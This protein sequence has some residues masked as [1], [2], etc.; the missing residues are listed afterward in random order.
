M[1]DLNFLIRVATWATLRGGFD[2]VLDMASCFVDESRSNGRALC[3]SGSAGPYLGIVGEDSQRQ[4][5]RDWIW[6]AMD[7]SLP[8]SG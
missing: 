7:A 6:N 3:E 4:R 1:C 2:L 8:V 5:I